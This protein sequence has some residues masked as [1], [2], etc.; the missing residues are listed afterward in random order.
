MLK[1]IFRTTTTTSRTA[2]TTTK[3]SNK[4]HKFRQVAS[5]GLRTKK[6]DE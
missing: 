2:I 6:H 4:K 3:N 5:I 1:N